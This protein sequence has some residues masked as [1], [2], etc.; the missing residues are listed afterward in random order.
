M[1]PLIYIVIIAISN[2]SCSRGG[3]VTDLGG[4][5]RLKCQRGLDIDQAPNCRLLFQ[6]PNSFPRQL[7]SHVSIQCDTILLSP[8]LIF[9]D[10]VPRGVPPSL[11]RCI[12]VATHSN[13]VDITEAVIAVHSFTN[14]QDRN[15]YFSLVDYRSKNQRVDF[16]FSDNQIGASGREFHVLLSGDEI[17]SIVNKVRSEN[18]KTKHR[19]DEYYSS[20][21]RVAE[22][23]RDG[24]GGIDARK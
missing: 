5:F 13:I 20:Q 4:G 22:A 12:L 1:K 23:E 2:V 11:E 18:H 7:W 3:E 9:C 6:S 16:Q 15:I 17:A 21:S 19:G 14:A 8:N 10:R 24:P